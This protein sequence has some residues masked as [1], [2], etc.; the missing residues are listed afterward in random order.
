MSPNGLARFFKT[1]GLLDDIPRMM[2]ICVS[3]YLVAIVLLCIGEI[4]SA[5][6]NIS[7]DTLKI[8][9]L[10]ERKLVD[11]RPDIQILRE[12]LEQ[13]REMK[14][15][16]LASLREYITKEFKK[17]DEAR[18]VTS[19]FLAKHQERSTTERRLLGEFV[20]NHLNELL[21]EMASLRA[22]L[23]VEVT[24]DFDNPHTIGKKR[25]E[26]EEKDDEHDETDDFRVDNL[27]PG[28]PKVDD[29]DEYSDD[30]ESHAQSVY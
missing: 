18:K 30:D 23:E 22:L 16:E 1:Q 9:D 20:Y 10:V 5:L 2:M 24:E 17:N 14:V 4:L 6:L 11:T 7:E 28:D 26:L 3:F 12:K 29:E 25:Y 27:I 13:M 15:P 8:K 19:E 21:T